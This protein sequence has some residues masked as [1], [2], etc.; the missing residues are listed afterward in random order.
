MLPVIPAQAGIH[1]KKEPF[2]LLRSDEALPRSPCPGRLSL[3]NR[4][5]E[6]EPQPSREALQRCYIGRNVHLHPFFVPLSAR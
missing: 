6:A 2:A 4:T 3:P 1:C 5:T